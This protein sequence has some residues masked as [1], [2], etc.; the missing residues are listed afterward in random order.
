MKLTK[1]DEYI[2]EQCENKKNKKTTEVICNLDVDVIEKMQSLASVN[3][4]SLDQYMNMLIIQDIMKK[5]TESVAESDK[6]HR[7]IDV[8][9]FYR[10]EEILDEINNKNETLRVVCFEKDVMLVPATS[11]L[12]KFREEHSFK[13]ED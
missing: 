8:F 13:K 3:N 1:K 9:E 7:A 11:S 4:I 2:I 6:E 5:K 12:F 10:L